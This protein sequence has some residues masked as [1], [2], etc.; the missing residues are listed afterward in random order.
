MVDHNTK[1]SKVDHD[2]PE[3][4]YQREKSKFDWRVLFL[5]IIL[6]ATTIVAV[7]VNQDVTH[8]DT[9]KD[10]LNAIDIDNGDLKIN[11]DHYQ[12]V[13]IELSE[14]IVINKSGTYHLT[15]NLQNGSITVDAH[16]GEVRLI[17]D[18]VTINNLAGPAIYCSTAEDLVIEL[19]GENNLSDSYKYSSVYSDDVKGAIYS[20]ADLIFSG[21][22][23]LNLVANHEDG[24]VGKDDLKFINGSY[25]I[26]SAD[27]AIRGT[28][29]VYI[30]D[31][32]FILNSTADAIKTTDETNFGKG[33]IL[34]EKG[35]FNITSN[36]KG[37]KA[38]HNIIIQDGEF[39]I[40]S[41]DDAIH[42]DN[43]IGIIGGN[44]SINASDDA[45][46]ANSKLIIDDGTITVS[47]AH[48]GL[49]AQV[50]IINS[51]TIDLITTDDGINAGGGANQS[52]TNNPRSEMFNVDEN[53]I[54]AIN[55]GNIH[56][57]ASGDGIDSNGWLYINDG[58]I[59]V[60]GPIHDGNGAL[61]T[62]MGIIAK[63]GE[64]IALGSSGMAES[65]SKT[66]TI[67]NISVY[68]KKEQSP[69]TLIEITDSENQT[70]LS[71]TSAK[72]FSH[73]VAGT[74][75]F[76]L[77]E[78]YTIYLNNKKYQDFI[79]SDITTIIGNSSTNFD[80]KK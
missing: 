34:V 31:G 17:L 68:F 25:Y 76:K 45:I 59:I 67:N 14:S 24:I 15:G 36:A 30:I 1:N 58:T 5:F 79:T 44:L 26:T 22:G 20:R 23:S 9:T 72:K 28:D 19:I 27:D 70:I 43:Y 21:N 13:D 73:L 47:Q 7:F 69:N 54:I 32:N 8:E 35:N 60:D 18:N 29:S 80:I 4:I 11:W 2:L 52:T 78:K 62:G 74:P 42:S 65:L 49:E 6:I 41:H 63:G 71:Y 38:T 57:S 55:G 77:A 3:N 50:V 64:I 48:E 51:G 75:K 61:D 37:L 46:H 66:S 10:F 33:Y 16:V 53:C 40:E 56:I 39:S 12:T